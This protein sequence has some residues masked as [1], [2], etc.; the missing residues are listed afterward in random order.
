MRW[1]WHKMFCTPSPGS[2]C[3]PCAA[4]HSVAE[5]LNI[6][7]S[8]WWLRWRLWTTDPLVCPADDWRSPPGG[9]ARPPVSL[10][11]SESLA[12]PT[13]SCTPPRTP[14]PTTLHTNH[15]RAAVS[16]L[17]ARGRHLVPQRQHDNSLLHYFNMY[18]DD[19]VSLSVCSSTQHI[20]ETG[21]PN[22]TGFCACSLWLWL[23]PPLV[24]MRYITSGFVDNVIFS[25]NGRM[26]QDELWNQSTELY[27]KPWTQL[28][29]ASHWM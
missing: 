23:G 13:H 9:A 14:P 2:N 24:A 15:T 17:L 20:S 12:H 26:A 21:R 16:S 10:C 18:C 1:Q 4:T 7:R 5:E 29:I 11:S 3:P 27:K 6:H 8:G 28:P 22:F 25:H 19:H